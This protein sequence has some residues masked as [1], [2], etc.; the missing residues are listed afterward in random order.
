MPAEKSPGRTEIPAKAG[1]WYFAAVQDQIPAFAGISM[2]RV[3]IHPFHQKGRSAAG[4][5]GAMTS[6]RQRPLL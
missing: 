1:I 5:K 2:V 4:I 6:Q 3:D